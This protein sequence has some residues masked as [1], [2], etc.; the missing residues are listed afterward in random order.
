MFQFEFTFKFEY[1]TGFSGEFKIQYTP[2]QVIC[3]CK[4]ILFHVIVG[5]SKVPFLMC[6]L[7]IPQKFAA[8]VLALNLCYL[9]F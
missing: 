3:E 6:T 1:Q 5:N 9:F 2:T 4:R 7:E 8:Q